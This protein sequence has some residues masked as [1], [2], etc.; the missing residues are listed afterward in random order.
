MPLHQQQ[1]VHNGKEMRN[2]EKLSAAGVGDGDL[3]MMVANTSSSNSR[4]VELYMNTLKDEG[5][6]NFTL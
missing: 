2:A 4:S 3:I 5:L 1:L 6:T